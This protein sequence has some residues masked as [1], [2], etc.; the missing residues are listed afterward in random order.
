MA[1]RTVASTETT[2]GGARRARDAEDFSRWR[3]GESDRLL[4]VTAAVRSDDY[5]G[6]VG[7]LADRIRAKRAYW[8][9]MT[10]GK[11]ALPAVRAGLRDENADVR[12]YCAKAL[13]HLVDE[14]AFPDI[15]GLLDDPDARV[16]WDALHALACD[17]CKDNACRPDKD[18]VLPRAVA[19]L[20]ADPSPHVRAISCE[21]V[22]RWVHSDEVAVT[23]LVSA[24]HNDPSP[25]VRKKA[26][27]YSPG[28]T[29]YR[30]DSTD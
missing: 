15:I 23:A 26:G 3:V 20:A 14:T 27:W 17:R 10:S 22:G 5:A 12:M 28:G 7:L 13:D 11:D 29:I 4:P 16:R 1:H 19:L 6:W 21:V 18:A 30:K 24:H 9:L 2:A 8:H 25:A